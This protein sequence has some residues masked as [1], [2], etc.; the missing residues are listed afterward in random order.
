MLLLFI[1]LQILSI[2]MLVKYSK[3]H[4]ARYMEYAYEVTGTINLRYNN[5]TR[6][7]SLAE[8]NR[9]LADEN[10]RLANELKQNFTR[11]DTAVEQKEIETF[12]DSTPVTRK[13]LWRT[14]RV[15]N[16]SVSGQNNY[17]TLQRGRLQGVDKD[18]AVISPAGIVGIVTDASD[19]MSIVMSL[20][21]RK[22]NTSV[23]LKNSG[24]TGI[25]EWDGTNP[26]RL[27]LRGI[28]KSAEIKKGDTVLT[29]NLSLNFPEGLHVGTIA[30]FKKETGG[31]NY[32][33][34]LKPGANFYS[35]EFVSVIEN[36]FLKEQ[37]ELE[38]RAKRN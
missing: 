15:I 8:N 28:P 19:N 24:I 25:L 4:E 5:F 7:F 31:N 9:F 36:L 27:I 17:I 35:L 3:S 11:I 33:I 10:T 14:A 30:E 1:I 34:W 2:S 12:V 13:Y 18:M 16:N 22:S 26:Q 32:M 37:L 20:L 38:Q 6:Y 21:H 23:A 29:S